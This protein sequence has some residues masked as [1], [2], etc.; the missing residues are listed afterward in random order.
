VPIGT[1]T[2]ITYQLY[3]LIVVVPQAG[4]ELIIGD[5]PGE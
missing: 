2:I 5:I 1:L 4:N 3:I